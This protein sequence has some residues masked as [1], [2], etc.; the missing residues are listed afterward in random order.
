MKLT[1]KTESEVLKVY[2]AW[3]NA[4]INGDVKTYDF[5]L[6]DS[7]HFIG[8]TN[9]EEFLT[10]NDTTKFFEKTADQL[11]GKTDL[12]NR[13]KTI[14]LFEGLVFVTEFFDAYF[15]ICNEWSYYGR[16]RFSSVMRKNKEGWRF[17][18]QHFSMPDSKSD[19][20]QTIGFDKVNSENLESGIEKC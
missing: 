10:K 19:D 4:Y 14:E 1:K 18:Y 5:F 11:A 17:I 6:D 15:L 20:G 3:L 12:K 7:Y 2:D 9:N 8:S 16:F 13:I